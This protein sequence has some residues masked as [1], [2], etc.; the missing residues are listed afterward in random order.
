MNKLIIL[1]LTSSIKKIKKNWKI[2]KIS[3]EIY[4][5]NVSKFLNINFFHN[6]PSFFYIRT[7][8]SD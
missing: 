5:R 1:Y 6:L 7:T 3:M 8:F 2:Q 4:F